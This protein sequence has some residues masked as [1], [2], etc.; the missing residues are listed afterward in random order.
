LPST[1]IGVSA[2]VGRPP[3]CRLGDG[4]R[5]ISGFK[6]STYFEPDIYGRRILT[7][8]INNKSYY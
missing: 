6:S 3:R 5:G 7:I 2:M 1:G 8:C 4:G